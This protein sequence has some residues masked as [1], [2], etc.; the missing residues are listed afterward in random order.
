MFQ[1]ERASDAARSREFLEIGLAPKI[2][3]GT[4][5]SILMR[6]SY[7]A[8]FEA[9]RVLLEYGGDPR[10]TSDGRSDSACRRDFQ[11]RFRDDASFDRK[12]R[13]R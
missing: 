7:I 8:N 10:L 6:A 12:R 5:N 11:R 2:R 1:L 3:R 13:G 9:A 4:G